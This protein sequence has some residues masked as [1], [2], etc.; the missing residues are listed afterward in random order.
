MRKW[1]NF[2]EN[3][4]KLLE[5]GSKWLDFEVNE[6]TITYR[7]ATTEVISLR[8]SFSHLPALVVQAPSLPRLVVQTGCKRCSSQ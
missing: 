1:A 7:L 8:E 6:T 5:F 2:M 3:Q 4:D